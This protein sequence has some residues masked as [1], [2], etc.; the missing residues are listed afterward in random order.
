MSQKRYIDAR[1]VA[2]GMPNPGEQRG[3][4]TGPKV[5]MACRSC[6]VRGLF[7]TLATR[8]MMFGLKHPV[9]YAECPTCG[10]LQIVNIPE[11]LGDYYPADYYSLSVN[12][13]PPKPSSPWR[14][15]L[16]HLL[17]ETPG[18]SG[19]SK[20]LGLKYPFL[21][22][23]RT[24]GAKLDSGVLDIGCGSGRLLRRMQ[25]SGFQKLQ[26][27]DPYAPQEFDEPGFKIQKAELEAVKGSFGLIIISHVLEHVPEPV[28]MLRR[29]KKL[30]SPGGAILVRVPVAGSHVAREF[31]P[32]WFNL[33]PPRHLV[34]PSI[35]GM[36]AIADRAGLKI[37]H[38]DFDSM[39]DSLSMSA[40]YR[41]GISMK[42]AKPLPKKAR[43]ELRKEARRLNDAGEG[44]LAAY[45]LRA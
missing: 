31:G 27:V 11:N 8:E 7:N 22:W 23:A 29:A 12:S 28:E 30:L 4:A 26:G 3:V 17:V 35:K 5:E 2:D 34:V 40:S 13:S 24:A 15:A 36:H 39:E 32:D 38:T 33:D 16:A 10:S 6:G 44:D 41:S 42:D 20:N 14:R 9:E 1:P 45:Y 43:L 19:L 25:R 21:S 37:F 18:L